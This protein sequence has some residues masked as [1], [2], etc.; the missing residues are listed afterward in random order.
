MHT[1]LAR[2]LARHGV[3]YSRQRKE[4][5]EALAA[6]GRPLATPEIVERTGLPQSSVYR[7]LATF[8]QAGVVERI[9]FQSE[10]AMYELAE[11]VTAR[12]HHHLVCTVCGKVQDTD[13]TPR[14]E[15]S[16]DRIV[17]TV[18]TGNRFHPSSHRL[19]VLGVCAACA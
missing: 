6:A 1:L 16:L 13:M 8:E 5:V 12:H 19:D 14:L 17:T 4:L 18:A 15:Q 11:D 10:H 9:A 2:R 7:N 3:R